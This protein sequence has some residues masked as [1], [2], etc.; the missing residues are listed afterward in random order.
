M[1]G[2]TDEMVSRAI[3]H[4]ALVFDM[5]SLGNILSRSMRAQLPSKNLMD[6]IVL[7]G[8]STRA[9]SEIDKEQE[10]RELG[11]CWC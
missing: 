11:Q 9:A 8:T 3:S 2:F 4:H 6:R 5:I 7:S 1:F 10:E